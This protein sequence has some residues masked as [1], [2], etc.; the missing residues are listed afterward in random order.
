MMKAA[1][2]LHETD[3]SIAT[4]AERVGYD[5]APAFIK[6]LKQWRGIGP[7]AYRKARATS[8]AAAKRAEPPKP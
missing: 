2:W 8:S 6:A 7:G 3:H 4:I 1:L 5:S